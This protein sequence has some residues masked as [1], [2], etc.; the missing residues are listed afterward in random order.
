[1]RFV[2]FQQQFKNFV[3]ISRQD[4]A[5]VEPNF[6]GKNLFYWQKKGYIK[7]VKKGFYIFSDLPIFEKSQ[8]SIA[9]RIYEPS[10]ISFESALSY[11]GIIPEA[12][13]SITSATSKKTKVLETP[14]GKFSYTSLKPELIFGYSAQ[15][16]NEDYAYALKYNHEEYP[17]LIADL[18]KT[19]LDYFYINNHINEESDFE[20][21]RF[22]IEKFKYERKLD[23]EKLK[24][25][26]KVFNNKT[27]EKRVNNFL[28]YIQNA[29]N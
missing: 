23:T 7:M 28:N 15:R 20:G 16:W 8:F 14:I 21:L 12:V 5:L 17:Y 9:N 11:Y 29:V 25:Y 4:I 18:E 26:L 1:M 24:G 27:L 3:V 2:E 10:Y 19:I 6:D 13:F 22:D